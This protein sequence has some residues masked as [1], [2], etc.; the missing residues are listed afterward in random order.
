M[1]RVW[2]EGATN[3]SASLAE[4]IELG[5]EHAASRLK[6]RQRKRQTL[7]IVYGYHWFE[8]VVSML[9]RALQRS[10][11]FKIRLHA[12]AALNALRSGDAYGDTITTIF[13][14]ILEQLHKINDTYELTHSSAALSSSTITSGIF[15]SSNSKSLVSESST[16]VIKRAKTVVGGASAARSANS[17]TLRHFLH[18]Q[19]K[20]LPFAGR[21]TAATATFR[22]VS[23]LSER[24]SKTAAEI[25]SLKYVPLLYD[26]LPRL[27]R[28]LLDVSDPLLDL[29]PM[30]ETLADPKT[31]AAIDA[32]LSLGGRRKRE[33]ERATPHRGLQPRES[34]RPAPRATRTAF[35]SAEGGRTSVESAKVEDIS[36]IARGIVPGEAHDT[37]SP[38]SGNYGGE[39]GGS[40]I[41]DNDA[42]VVD[43]HDEVGVLEWTTGIGDELDNCDVATEQD[44]EN[45]WQSPF[46][47]KKKVA[48][49]LLKLRDVLEYHEQLQVRANIHIFEKNYI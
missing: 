29:L 35:H 26:K 49:I 12:T 45:V 23:S 7:A 3:L 27:L 46:T 25:A 4:L 33:N 32:A 21:L 34:E 11:N 40:N 10:A 28:H 42:A 17:S 15:V 48:T 43:E 14:C 8:D 47:R 31:R 24:V 36:M 16:A 6:E 38:S 18:N 19:I 13:K 9:V 22:G 2:S 20:T 37:S 5:P 30:A 44:E 1:K 39:D 41:I